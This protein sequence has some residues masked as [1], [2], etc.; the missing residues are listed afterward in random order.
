MEYMLLFLELKK[1]LELYFLVILY[2]IYN[3]G[4]FKV[5]HIWY[6]NFKNGPSINDLN[7]YFH[8]ISTL[9]LSFFV[10]RYSLTPL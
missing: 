7:I 5:D 9:F 8:V 1:K 10:L 2:L 4:L 3:L 6:E